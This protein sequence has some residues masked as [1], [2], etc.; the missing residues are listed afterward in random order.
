MQQKGFTLTELMV[1]VAIVSILV[2]IAIPQFHEFQKK[3]ADSA[4]RSDARHFLTIAM[5]NSKK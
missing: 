4:A 1:V 3:A 2:A 5:L